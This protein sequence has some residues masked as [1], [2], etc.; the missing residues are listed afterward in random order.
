MEILLNDLGILE[1]DLDKAVKSVAEILLNEL[2][3]II[4]QEV[5]TYDETWGGR[6]LEF[7]DSWEHKTVDILE[8]EIYQNID[9]MKWSSEDWKHGNKWKS[10]KEKGILLSDI[11]ENGRDN[12]AF[13][14]PAIQARPFWS[15]FLQYVD[16][17]LGGI[18]INECSK[19]G[20]IV[21]R[22][23]FSITK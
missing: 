1:A 4:E 18:F 6:T 11:I 9:T 16:N 23:D 12:S 5:Y 20:L 10:L 13:G 7:K 14:F 19:L 21:S 2:K 15:T 17:N 8:Q 22:G 3:N